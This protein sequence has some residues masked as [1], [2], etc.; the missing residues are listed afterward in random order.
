MTRKAPE[1][2]ILWLSGPDG[3]PR[4]E[5]C[6]GDTA[7]LSQN[8][9]LYMVTFYARRGDREIRLRTQAGEHRILLG[10]ISREQAITW[11][12]RT[13]AIHGLNVRFAQ[14]RRDNAEIYNLF[15][16]C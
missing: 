5:L 12:K 7:A 1:V 15:F 6:G 13:G 9:G 16:R 10:Y 3:G 14:R 2:K 8:D 4:I 11:L